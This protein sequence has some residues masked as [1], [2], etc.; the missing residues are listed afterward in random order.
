MKTETKSE[1]KTFKFLLLRGG[2]STGNLRDGTRRQYEKGDV[3]KTTVDLA[4]KFGRNKFH[5]LREKGEV[6]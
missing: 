1:Q 4:K 3:I 5:L 6:T 2:H